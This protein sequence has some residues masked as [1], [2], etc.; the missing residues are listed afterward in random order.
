LGDEDDRRCGGREGGETVVK[1]RRKEGRTSRKDCSRGGGTFFPLPRLNLWPIVCWPI[2]EETA[3]ELCVCRTRICQAV[4]RGGGRTVSET[5]VRTAAI[6]RK[7]TASP[8]G[9][10]RSDRKPEKRQKCAEV[11]RR[12][13]SIV[14][15]E[16]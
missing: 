6:N 10:V 2:P 5:L 7:L 1:K 8:A 12:E 3:I 14:R 11:H 9:E 13:R 16:H 15:K 4:S